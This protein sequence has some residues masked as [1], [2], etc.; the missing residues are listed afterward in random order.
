MTSAPIRDFE[1][2]QG[3]DWSETFRILDEFD[4][5]LDLSLISTIKGEAYRFVNNEKVIAFTF[6]FALNTTTDIITVSVARAITSALTV[7]NT[8]THPNSI[9]FYDYEVTFTSGIRDRIQ[10]GRVTVYREMTNI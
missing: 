9:F 1:I 8:K 5:P 10:Q 6:T 2:S 3:S 4:T 7:G